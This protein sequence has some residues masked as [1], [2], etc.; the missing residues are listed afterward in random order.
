MPPAI[1]SRARTSCWRRCSSASTTARASTSTRRWA[2]SSSCRIPTPRTPACCRRSKRCSTRCCSCEDVMSLSPISAQS[3]LAIQQ[4][5]DMRAQ[6]DDLQRQL[7]TG[8]KSA[9]YAGLGLDS[10]VTVSLNSQLA[11]IGGYDNTIDNVGTRI[12]LMNTALGSM[13]D[14]A[15]QVKSALAQAPLG[16][17][18]SGVTLAQQTGQ[19]ALDQLLSMLNTQSGGRYLFSGRA[20]DQP[21]VET[22]DHI[23]NGDGARAGLKQ[24]I[25]ERTQADL[26]VGGLGRLTL[27]TAGSTVSITDDTSPFGFK[28]ASVSS[29]LSNA[30]VSGPSGAPATL[31]VDFSG[32]N[33]NDGDAITVRLDLPDGSSENLTLTATT[34]SPPGANQ[35]AIGGTT[36][37]TAAN[38]QAALNTAIGKLA[39][40]SLTAA[41]AVAASNDFFVADSSNPPQ[42]VNGPPFDTAT[43]MIAGTA[44]N[45]VIWYTGE[46]GASPARDTATA[47]VDQSLVVSY[48]AR[49]NETGIRTLVQNVAT[50]AAVAISPSDPNAPDLRSALNQRLT[51]NMN[52]PGSQTISDIQTELASAQSSLTAA[53]DRHQQTSATLSDFL[54]QIQGVSNEDVGAQILALQTRMQAS[55]Q[56]TALL[57]QTSLVNYLK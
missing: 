57:F 42:R 11:A 15:T 23:L 27:G 29:S 21:A 6:F 39:D 20:T 14:L 38:F 12:G 10:G 55:M 45:T 53:K 46:A 52:A 17:N 3:A 40:T 34:S 24:L 48:G 19:N 7:S 51:Q 13:T 26:G 28:L 49:A 54:Q 44:A 43:G 8:Q 1:S 56:T 25:S 31:S 35:F 47:R 16:V 4:L 33:P 32:G 22:L 30:A 41:S 37:Q 18:G 36:A 5:V 2:T 50:L 9:N